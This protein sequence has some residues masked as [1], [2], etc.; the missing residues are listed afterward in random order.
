MANSRFYHS[1]QNIPSSLLCVKYTAQE[2]A[3]VHVVVGPLTWER[4]DGIDL[5]GIHHREVRAAYSCKR[6]DRRLI[7]GSDLSSN[8][9]VRNVGY[10]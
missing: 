2:S 1:Y 3:R 8:V 7:A 6:H 5:I 10:A 9:K 4:S